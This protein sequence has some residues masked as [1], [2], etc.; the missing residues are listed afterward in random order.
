MGVNNL[1]K[2]KKQEDQLYGIKDNLVSGIP[3]EYGRGEHHVKLAYITPEEASILK[4][5]DLYDSNPPH[6]GPKGIPN[7][8]DGLGGA[9]GQGDAEAGGNPG[10]T[11]GDAAAHGNASSTSS[12]VVGSESGPV[13]S[14]TGV[15]TAPGV[16]ENAHNQNMRARARALNAAALANINANPNLGMAD[17]NPSPFGISA[18]LTPTDGLSLGQ[19]LGYS[20]AQLGEAFGNMSPGS[21]MGGLVGL[22][23]GIPGLG[24]IAG[25]FDSP[26]QTHPRSPGTTTPFEAERSLFDRFGDLDFSDFFGPAQPTVE[27]GGNRIPTVASGTTIDADDTEKQAQI[28]DLISRGFT[29]ELAQ[30]IVDAGKYFASYDE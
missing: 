5:L 24:L 15:V 21:I 4:K 27:Q 9:P 28:D 22:A 20:G 18:G 23:T 30:R 14:S 8:N 6:D 1:F 25:L 3:R 13:T 10:G 17:Y 29:E 11:A 16:V 26:M 2:S 19:S 7:Y 12:G